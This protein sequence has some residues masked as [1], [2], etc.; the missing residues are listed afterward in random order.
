MQLLICVLAVVLS[1]CQGGLNTSREQRQLRGLQKVF[2]GNRGSIYRGKSIYDP[3]QKSVYDAISGSTFVKYDDANKNVNNLQNEN[4]KEHVANSDSS[5]NQ[6]TTSKMEEKEKFYQDLAQRILNVKKQGLSKTS[7]IIHPQ[8]APLPNY[9]ESPSVETTSNVDRDIIYSNETSIEIKNQILAESNNPNSENDLPSNDNEIPNISMQNNTE[10][11]DSYMLNKEV[12]PTKNDEIIVSSLIDKLRGIM[13][14][15]QEVL[16]TITAADTV[17]TEE[18]VTDVDQTT[19]AFNYD[20][21]GSSE[22]TTEKVSSKEKLDHSHGEVTNFLKNVAFNGNYQTDFIRE[23]IGSFNNLNDN[24]VSLLYDLLIKPLKYSEMYEKKDVN[25]E[26]YS[27]TEDHENFS[28]DNAIYFNPSEL[29]QQSTLRLT[30]DGTNWHPYRSAPRSARGNSHVNIITAPPV[31]V[32]EYQMVVSSSLNSQRPKSLDSQFQQRSGFASDSQFQQRSGFALDD[33]QFQQR[34]GLALD[35]QFEKR[36]GFAPV[37]NM[38]LGVGLPPPDAME[39]LPDGAK[40][41]LPS[42]LEH[43]PVIPNLRFNQNG[44]PVPFS[45]PTSSN[46]RR[47]NT[48]L[49]ALSSLPNFFASF[50]SGERRNQQN[51]RRIS[52]PND[53]QQNR[54]RITIPNDDQQNRRRINIPIEDPHI[55]SQEVRYDPRRQNSPTAAPPPVYKRETS[56]PFR[57]RPLADINPPKEEFRVPV[58]YNENYNNYRKEQPSIDHRNS[59]DN[60]HDHKPEENDNRDYA[61]ADEDQS[62]H[63]SVQKEDEGDIDTSQSQS[64]NQY[65]DQPLPDERSKYVPKYNHAKPSIFPK[66]N[67]V[68]QGSNIDRINTN[69]RS[70]SDYDSPHSLRNPI[71][72]GKEWIKF[73]HPDETLDRRDAKQERTEQITFPEETQN[74]DRDEKNTYEYNDKN[75]GNFAQFSYGRPTSFE[76]IPSDRRINDNKVTHRDNIGNQQK[77]IP[78]DRRG[79]QDHVVY[80]SFEDLNQKNYALGNDEQNENTK[81]NDYFEPVPRGATRNDEGHYIHENNNYPVIDRGNDESIG[82]GN[83]KPSKF[84]PSDNKIIPQPEL[85]NINH[86]DHETN[87]DQTNIA[88]NISDNAPEKVIPS[89]KNKIKHEN[90]DM[91]QSFERSDAKDVIQTFKRSDAKQ[92]KEAEKQSKEAEEESQYYYQDYQYYDYE[93]E[94]TEKPTN[95]RKFGVKLSNVTEENSQNSKDNVSNNEMDEF[96]PDGKITEYAGIPPLGLSDKPK[97]KEDEPKKT[98][99]RNIQK[100]RNYGPALTDRPDNKEIA[101]DVSNE[102][103]NRNKDYHDQEISNQDKGYIDHEISNRDKDY[104]EHEISNRDKN[105]DEYEISNRDE[106]YQEHEISNRDKDYH[107]HEISNRD[108]DYHEHE[109]SMNDPEPSIEPTNAKVPQIGMREV[110]PTF[111]SPIFNHNMKNKPD[112]NSQDDHESDKPIEL[113]NPENNHDIESKSKIQRK[114]PNKKRNKVF[115]RQYPGSA[116]ESNED[117]SGKYLYK[118][119]ALV[120]QNSDNYNTRQV[121]YDNR[122]TISSENITHRNSNRRIPKENNTITST[123]KKEYMAY[124]VIGAC[125]GLSLIS[126]SGVL[127]IF[128]FKKSCGSKQIISRQRWTEDSLPRVTK[129]PESLIENEGGHKLGSWFTGKGGDFTNSKLRSNMALPVVE[130]LCRDQ[131]ERSS[132]RRDLISLATSSSGSSSPPSV[133]NVDE[134]QHSLKGRSPEGSWR[135]KDSDEQNR[136]RRLSDSDHSRASVREKSVRRK[137][138]VMYDPMESRDLSYNIRTGAGD[139]YTTDS[140][141]YDPRSVMSGTDSEAFIF[142][143]NFDSRMSKMSGTTSQEFG[144]RVSNDLRNF[145]HRVQS[146]SSPESTIDKRQPSK[147]TQPEGKSLSRDRDN[148]QN[149]VFLEFDNILKQHGQWTGSEGHNSLDHN[150]GTLS[151]KRS[152]SPDSIEAEWKTNSGGRRSKRASPRAERL[153]ERDLSGKSPRV[154]RTPVHRQSG[155]SHK[156]SR[157]S[158]TIAGGYE[159]TPPIPPKYT[160]STPPKIDSPQS[161]PPRPPK[162]DRLTASKPPL[163]AP[164]S[165][166]FK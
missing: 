60:Y 67:I 35:S 62:S 50:F 26:D 129:T 81:S 114:F 46:R 43:K 79:N 92:I 10:T 80:D 110:E 120:P 164:S 6:P 27:L 155:R 38:R 100:N 89:I 141:F 131:P 71:T 121:V 53:N 106:N 130:G 158:P 119:V 12:K 40:L 84:T 47:Q 115:K 116:T 13:E 78:L 68:R 28:E 23:L 20:A 52:N 69:T 142:D 118:T 66:E 29:D 123:E 85:I 145:R 33:S 139:A 75:S 124:I 109:I 31:S 90:Y 156:S 159:K 8:N 91:I 18:T 97:F 125:I 95:L 161:A 140:E 93:N 111:Q 166:P 19:T 113:E 70:N 36:A 74:T 101:R 32:N 147:T 24:A 63:F 45:N 152:N 44:V 157:T 58:D 108:K 25:H 132:S 94:P 65:H 3:D 15:D 54:R 11:S 77:E 21:V 135:H 9:H 122:E 112:K 49:S 55:R 151:E 143:R 34:S 59:H 162:P 148:A 87:Y 103:F 57:N 64:F 7:F 153:A 5:T 73:S 82:L 72:E 14:D 4:S 160:P 56:Q 88:F 96:I 61:Y 48:P 154:E 42:Q 137:T 150:Q 76:R 30:E 16:S 126:I 138:D 83:R 117:Y 127:L 86:D 165:H 39:A 107:E 133:H 149:E 51:R 104:H 37:E 146:S 136:A 98:F 17:V 99:T 163:H 22:S 134:S 102:I 105:Y 128:R 1:K 144:E 41:I 2:E